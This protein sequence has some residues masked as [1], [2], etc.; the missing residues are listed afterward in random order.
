MTS[1][2]IS[3]THERVSAEAEAAQRVPWP[4]VTG[5]EAVEDPAAAGDLGRD[6]GG[7][8]AD[9]A[10]DIAGP[11]SD[12]AGVRVD[13]APADPLGASVTH[14]AE[15]LRATLRGLRR[16]LRADWLGAY[17]QPCDLA[18]LRAEPGW[19]PP[20]TEAA[21]EPDAA[22]AD[23]AAAIDFGVASLLAAEE[24]WRELLADPG[25][26]R[27]LGAASSARAGALRAALAA[28]AQRAGGAGS[29]GEAFGEGSRSLAP[30]ALVRHAA[31]QRRRLSAAE[32]VAVVPG[33]DAPGAW[34]P[35]AAQTNT[36]NVAPGGGAPAGA[37]AAALEIRVRQAR[38]ELASGLMLSEPM[39]ELIAATTPALLAG[40]P[41]LFIGET[42]GAKTALAERLAAVGGSPD[43]EFVSG[44]GDITSAQV[45]GSHEL[46]AEHGATTTAFEPGPL[47]RAMRRGVPIILDEINAMPPE[48]LKRLNRILQ[49]RPGAT[50]AVQEQP[51]HSVTI[52]PGFA[53]IATA[54]EYAPERYRGIE[55]LSAELVNRFGANTYRVHYPDAGLSA[56]DVP[57][58]NLLLAAAVVADES[59]SL[60]PGLGIAELEPLARAAFISQQVFTGNRGDGFADYIGTER[61]LDD[62]PG[63][64]ET[65]IAPRTLAALLD[66][67]MLQGG[68]SALPGALERFADG[69]VHADDR[70]VLRLILSS[71]GLLE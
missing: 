53:V 1:P 29:P 23:A 20:A 47:L 71:Q 48:F 45:L 58:E 54:N 41:V 32:Q 16:A 27:V 6:L 30:E 5:R 14:Q 17:G 36:P 55:P 8:S 59:G 52:A 57:A 51:G 15:E 28:T 34:A 35:V 4:G 39:R 56:S 11:V 68:A 12:T 61:D 42:G 67:V 24:R 50:F 66:G 60:P 18:R 9:P 31:R 44:Y 49:L 13:A 25:H 40:S 70:A 33:A 2:G 3:A 38:R 22:A 7:H 19:R 63:L 21:R 10:G 65:V 62:L 37:L 26:A 43:H 69:I 64:S 46:R